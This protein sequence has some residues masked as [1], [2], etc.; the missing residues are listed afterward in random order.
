MKRKTILNLED[1]LESCKL[2][3]TYIQ[4]ITKGKFRKNP[5]RKDAV[6]RRLGIIGEAIKRLPTSLRRKHPD[7]PWKLAAGTRDR[8]IHDYR[9]LEEEVIWETITKGIPK[10][11]TQVEKILKELEEN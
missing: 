10:L 2:I 8:V 6:H 7:V 3:E 9:N 4:G 1:V 5:L 11:K